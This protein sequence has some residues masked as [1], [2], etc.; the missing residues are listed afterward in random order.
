[1]EL[2]LPIQKERWIRPLHLV[3]KSVS[4]LETI[5]PALTLLIVLTLPFHISK[6]AVFQMSQLY[7]YAIALLGLNLLIGYNGQFSLG[8]GAFYAL[9]SYSAAIM[10]TQWH[11]PYLWAIPL[12][13]LTCFTF[14]FLFGIPALRFEKVYLALVSFSLALSTPQLIKYF[15]KW[16]GGPMG[17]SLSKPKPPE[18]L[19][20]VHLTSDQW[21]YYLSF[22]ALLLSFW[23]AW[24][25][26][27]GD[28]GR[29][30]MAIRDQRI[31]A[32]AMGVNESLYKSLAFGASALFT[33]IAGA[34]GAFLSG[35]VSPEGFE[36]SLSIFF[37]V[38]IAIGGL[39]SISGALFGAAFILFIPNFTQNL[40][41]AAP[42]AIFGSV[43]IGFMYLMPRGVVGLWR[44]FKKELTTLIRVE[45]DY[46]EQPV[47]LQSLQ[48]YFKKVNADWE[49]RK[50]IIL[51]EYETIADLG[52][53][54]RVAKAY[55]LAKKFSQAL[56]DWEKKFYSSSNFW[57]LDI[58][59]TRRLIKNYVR[60]KTYCVVI[61]LLNP[62]RYF[63]FAELT[64]Q[65]RLLVEN[66]YEE[67]YLFYG[68]DTSLHVGVSAPSSASTSGADFYHWNAP[69][70]PDFKQE[71]TGYGKYI[72]SRH[73]GKKI[74]VLMQD[75]S[76]G[77]ELLEGLRSGLGEEKSKNIIAIQKY[78]PGR[79]PHVRKQVKNLK[80]SGAEIILTFATP[81]VTARVIQRM[82][83]LAWK[84]IHFITSGATSVPTVLKVAGIEIS[85]GTISSIYLKDPIDAQ[86]Q[87]VDTSF[88]EWVSWMKKYHPTGD[89][90]DILN[91]M[92][93]SAAQWIVAV[94]KAAGQDWSAQSIDRS[95]MS[96]Q[97]LSLP[98]ILPGLMV[99]V[100]DV[101]FPIAHARMAQFNG[102]KWEI[103]N[104]APVES[105]PI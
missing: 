46:Y 59:L 47:F 50:K 22:G 48:A 95:R 70:R 43:L 34:L 7:V 28:V 18:I 86:W 72:Q 33:G 64:T 87:D 21:L 9:G 27:R 26:I 19:K 61:Q 90:R 99:G 66:N 40:S 15:E 30:L 2:S 60:A 42:M 63:S 96:I 24:N 38:G 23:F 55:Q 89:R 8:H 78:A 14:G 85:K 13:G 75:D 45:N 100:T 88:E 62:R 1:M 68:I 104:E 32:V 54:Q 3:G 51:I 77:N 65:T 97:S 74:G 35:F 67:F 80:N 101:P 29:A 44:L 39:A 36:A 84:P 102:E 105:A 103:L 57:K 94:L 20:F 6:F 49:V 5:V 56:Y 83:K 81:K 37:L 52:R 4:V 11:V 31:A 17:I 79:R 98:M 41:K 16:T 10:I 92:G 91:V 69:F 76:L 58:T 93:Y 82:A 73:D 12:A 53:A 71:G 25:L